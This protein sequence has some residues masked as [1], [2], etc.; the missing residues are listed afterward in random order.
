MEEVRR[1]LRSVQEELR[2][3]NYYYRAFSMGTVLESWL[4]AYA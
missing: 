1:D 3:G 2:G 4:Q